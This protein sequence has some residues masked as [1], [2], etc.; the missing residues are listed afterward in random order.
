MSK[1]KDIRELFGGPCDLCKR[2]FC[3]NCSGI[4]SSEIR[5]FTSQSRVLS[6]Y[7]GDCLGTIRKAIPNLPK[8][9]DEIPNLE[10]QVID[11]RDQLK[12]VKDSIA[13]TTKSYADVLQIQKDAAELKGNIV[14]LEDK[15]ESIKIQKPSTLSHNET[16]GPAFEEMM[17]REK[18]STNILLFGL[19]ESDKP[20]KEERIKSEN[21]IVKDVL[22]QINVEVSDS[23]FKIH[24]LGKHDPEKVRP[25]KVIFSTKTLAIEALRK[26]HKLDNTSGMY[27]KSDQTHLQRKFLASL[28]AELKRRNEEGETDIKIKYIN[29]IPKI[30]KVKEQQ[31]KN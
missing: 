6:Y 22:K 27:I 26:K 30:I 31:P 8:I 23:E 14:K 21:I 11:I 18:R 3:R 13:A 28:V 12:E 5:A 15:V 9:I 17:E 29:S 10:K 7:C 19:K 25:I 1:S 2:I 4:S 20:N 16:V 24:R